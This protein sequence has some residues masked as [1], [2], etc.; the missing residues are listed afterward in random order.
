MLP[1]SS[2]T[3]KPLLFALVA[4][5]LSKTADVAEP[6][7]LQSSGSSPL[8]MVTVARPCKGH[9]HH[10]RFGHLDPTFCIYAWVAFYGG[11]PLRTQ[12]YFILRTFTAQPIAIQ[13]TTHTNNT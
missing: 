13:P 12:L 3:P 5:W 11:C 2:S 8:L 10:E 1:L 7:K 6:V 9:D 4:M